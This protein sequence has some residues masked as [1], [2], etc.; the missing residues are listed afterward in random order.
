MLTLMS[1]NRMM[2]ADGKRQSA[3]EDCKAVQGEV[4][5]PCN[6]M[7]NLESAR[8]WCLNQKGAIWSDDYCYLP[9]KRYKNYCYKN[10]KRRKKEPGWKKS[11][12]V[13]VLGM[14][15]AKPGLCPWRACK[16][17]DDCNNI[18][19]TCTGARKK[20]LGVC[21]GAGIGL[22]CRVQNNESKYPGY[23]QLACNV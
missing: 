8:Q 22:V 16:T 6:D 4:N 13:Q 19:M 9:P 14:G 18:D 23:Y 12:V 1:S 11:P 21:T 3:S 2:S 10:D 15:T 7:S 17:K 5:K 20:R